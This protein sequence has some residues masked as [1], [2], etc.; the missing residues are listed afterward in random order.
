MSPTP[1]APTGW[2]RLW[3]AIPDGAFRVMGVTFFLLYLAGRI[4]EYAGFPDIGPYYIPVQG[5]SLLG[6]PIYGDAIYVPAAK[7]LVDLTF[8]LVAVSFATRLPPRTRAA[9]ARQ[10][11]VPIVAAFMPL[12]PF[13]LR[14]ALVAFG[15][16]GGEALD[17]SLAWKDLTYQRFLLGV[18]LI[19]A[20]NAL[21]VWGYATLFRS[22]AI[23]AEA[24]ELKTHG[25]YRFVRHPI[26]LGQ[27][28]AQGGVWVVLVGRSWFWVAFYAVFV[29]LQ[30]YRSRVEDD[31]LEH[32]FGDT[33]RAFR[34][35]TWWFV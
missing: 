16:P 30:L 11:V 15:L 4:P 6:A 18:G 28:L 2:L 19:V 7:I 31:V 32:A 17:A 13:L 23:V 9:Q 21:D 34:D 26:Y 3:L 8:L 10:I 12:V 5:T 14:D 22:L 25:P 27:F 35:R 24:R 20:G 29:L 1:D 33:W